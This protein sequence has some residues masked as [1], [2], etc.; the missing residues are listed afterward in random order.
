MP[1]YLGHD[2]THLRQK[3]EITIGLVGASLHAGVPD[4][5]L[6]MLVEAEQI[7]QSLTTRCS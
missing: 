5:N 1:Q 3:V 2:P 7:A 4:Q 6:A